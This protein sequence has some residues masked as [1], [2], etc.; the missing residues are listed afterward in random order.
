MEYKIQNVKDFLKN[1][2][3]QFDVIVRRE[4]GKSL[5][6]KVHSATEDLDFK[7]EKMILPPKDGI[8][9]IV[10]R[11]SDDHLFHQGD[12]VE[13]DKIGTCFVFEFSEDLIHCSIADLFD[14]KETTVEINQLIIVEEVEAGEELED[15]TDELLEE[16]K[17]S[18]DSE[19]LGHHIR[20]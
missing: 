8:I 2:P 4:P 19:P 7:H 6:Y 10:K 15:L 16:D 5:A 20:I 14:Q 11:I 1:G 18:D 12:M 3:P 9:Q 17:A 13:I